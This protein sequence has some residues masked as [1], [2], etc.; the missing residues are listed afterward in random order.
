VPDEAGVTVGAT[1]EHRFHGLEPDPAAS[2]SLRSKAARLLPALADAPVLDA[3]VGVRVTR[4]G[5]RRPLL[6]PLPLHPQVW[7]FTALGARG[8][9]TAP[10]LARALPRHLGGSEPLPPGVRP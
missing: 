3:R 6:G 5:V 8:L 2:R 7:V 10:L 9:L 4:A 1:F